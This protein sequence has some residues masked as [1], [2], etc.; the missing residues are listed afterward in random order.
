[1]KELAG[2]AGAILLSTMATILPSRISE[3]QFLIKVTITD[4]WGAIAIGFVA[5][6]IGAKVLDKI[7]GSFGDHPTPAATV[8]TRT[9][10]QPSPSQGL[11]TTAQ[12]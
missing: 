6:Y 2:V 7:L 12:P 1:V 8:V 10:G 3:T 4:V 5:N 9:S 11:S